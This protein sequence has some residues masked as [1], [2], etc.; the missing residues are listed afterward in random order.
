MVAGTLLALCPAVLAKGSGSAQQMGSVPAL[1]VK[2]FTFFKLYLIVLLKFKP[3]LLVL[4]CEKPN[5]GKK[6]TS[7]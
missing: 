1:K 2:V 4:Q 3:V 7:M 5:V 6:N